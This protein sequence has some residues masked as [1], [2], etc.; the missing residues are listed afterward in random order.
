MVR[1]SST[2]SVASALAGAQRVSCLA[3]TLGAPMLRALEAAAQRGAH[4]RVRLEE[5]PF[6]DHSGG[7]ARAN[8]TAI[9]AL[10]KAGVDAAGTT[11]IHGKALQIDGTLF[12]D[13]LNW[14]GN[15]TDTVIAD[16]SPDDAQL[17][18][19]AMDGRLD[20]P[21][22]HLAVR[23]G[24]ALAQEALLIRSARAGDQVEIESESFGRA[25]SVYSAIEAAVRNGASVDLL[26][27]KRDLAN[28][29]HERA[30]IDRLERLGVHVHAG[31]YNG[32]LARVGEH[33]WTGSANATSAY[34]TPNEFD[35]GMA[36][37]DHNIVS[38]VAATFEQ[39]W[40]A[41]KAV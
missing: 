40:A 18:A 34:F 26:V 33:A 39:R 28:D 37:S 27:A 12:L 20:A 5:Q 2:S 17:I 9:A 29:P 4:V 7:I 8:A 35:W 19:D 16:S 36:S 32:K 30:A 21:S 25:N 3:Y 41:T 6:E 10:R 13:D 15:G 31:D 24:D 22:A 11:G 1:L 23:K 14:T 38:E